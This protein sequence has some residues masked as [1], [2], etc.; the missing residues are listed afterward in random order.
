MRKFS[1]L[2]L[3]LPFIFSFKKGST[4]SKTITLTSSDGIKITG[5]LYSIADEDA[6]YILLFH[7][8][9][10]S[11]GE[12]LEI[13]PK[14]NELGFNCLAIDQRSGKEVNGVINETHLEAKKAN[15]G[16]SYVDALP[17]LEA[18]YNYAKN[19]L[20][21]KKII[22]W[23]SSYSSSLVI[24]LGSKYGSDLSG[25]LSF[26]PGE[27]F[28]LNDKKMEDYAAEVQAPIFITSAKNEKNDWQG[29]FDQIISEKSFY[30]PETKGKHGSKA[31]W[32]KNEG[33]EAYWGA[34]EGFLK[35][36][37]Y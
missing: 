12:Y 7:Q 10:Y 1:F 6:P 5:D 23:G 27:Y 37:L 24:Y 19:E 35:S 3:L 9:G 20:K 18:A 28:K 32:E 14:L 22:I 36:I 33:H 8:A 17:D 25:I 15:K 29:I 21:A 31:L 26:S 13:A 34:V 30:L 2:L 4:D 16:T 11:R